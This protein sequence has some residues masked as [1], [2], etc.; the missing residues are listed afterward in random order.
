MKYELREGFGIGVEGYGVVDNLGNP[1][2]VREQEH[3]L[4]PVIY[5]EIKLREDFKLAVD[6]GLLFGLTDATPDVAL[7]VNYGIPLYKPPGKAE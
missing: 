4:G 6:V 7:K 1:P 2:P 5:N 3:R